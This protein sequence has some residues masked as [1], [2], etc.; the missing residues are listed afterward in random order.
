M[1]SHILLNSQDTLECL[2]LFV[3]IDSVITDIEEAY[4]E[5]KTGLKGLKVLKKLTLSSI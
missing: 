2:D 5:L 3:D 1:L 4:D